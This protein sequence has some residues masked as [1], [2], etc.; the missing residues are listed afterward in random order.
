[1]RPDGTDVIQVT[2]D[3]EDDYPADWGTYPLVN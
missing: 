2:N 3:P 1:M